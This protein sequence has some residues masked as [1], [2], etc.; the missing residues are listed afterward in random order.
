MATNGFLD[1]LDIRSDDPS[2]KI[3]ILNRDLRYRDAHG[4]IYTIPAEFRCDL[5]SVPWWLRSLAPPWHQSARAGLLHDCGYRWFEVWQCSRKK[6]DSLFSG[7]LRSDG[8]GRVRAGLMMMSVRVFG[9][10]AW[11]KWRNM[12]ENLKGVRPVDIFTP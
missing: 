3:V 7:A 8:V 5:A 10:K 12:P 4:T 11:K 9:K 6:V 2:K 1:P